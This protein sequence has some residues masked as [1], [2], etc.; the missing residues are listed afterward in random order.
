MKRRMMDDGQSSLSALKQR[1]MTALYQILYY[2]VHHGRQRTPLHIMNAQAIHEACK[3]STLIKNFNHFGLTISY[4]ELLRYHFDMASLIVESAQGNVPMPSHFDPEMFTIG[5]FDNFD[6]EE[7]TV[8][9]VGG[10]HDTV[11]VL[12]QDRPLE[13]RMKPNISETTVIHGAKG[14]KQE[15]PCQKL[16]EYIK[17]ARKPDLQESF[18]V[19]EE[20]YAMEKTHHETVKKKDV[21]WTLG[22][23]D[24]SDIQ[25]GTVKPTCGKQ[26]MPSWG[27]FNSL[28]SEETVKEKIV[29]FIPLIPNPVTEYSTVY[30]ALKNFQN[31][32]G[33]LKQTHIAV[34]CDEEVYH[35][36]RE[37]MMQHPMEFN[38][39][40]LCSEY[41]CKL[42][43]LFDTCIIPLLNAICVVCCVII[44]FFHSKSCNFAVCSSRIHTHT[45]TV[46]IH[47]ALYYQR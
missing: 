21:A 19:P 4:D 30:T 20:L 27:A 24:I 40:V 15:L 41:P 8:S 6:H 33:Q 29:G 38:D 43:V 26:C 12:F 10:S 16:Q 34:T 28:V 17:P 37:I 42:N 1:R 35:I 22:R 47:M 11:S 31:I 13:C 14:L 36:A 32:L 23:L 44:C 9:G 25:V 2:N 5:A 3:S 45:H 18:L 46:F 39:I 7:A